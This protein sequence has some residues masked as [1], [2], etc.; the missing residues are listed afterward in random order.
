[1]RCSRDP[2]S[3]FLSA[4]RWRPGAHISFK[5]QFLLQLLQE[6]LL[7]FWLHFVTACLTQAFPFQA[8]ASLGILLH[9]LLLHGCRY[10]G[11]VW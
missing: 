9:L 11:G 5:P 10:P 6:L 2:S 4:A 3:C 8:G 1:M 7:G